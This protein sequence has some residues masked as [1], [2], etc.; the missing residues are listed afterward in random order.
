MPM[1]RWF[2]IETVRE[3][4]K[5]RFPNSPS[6]QEDFIIGAY[7]KQRTGSYTAY[8]CSKTQAKKLRIR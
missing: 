8:G 6:R 3:E 7:H 4:A 2:G 5:K 1:V